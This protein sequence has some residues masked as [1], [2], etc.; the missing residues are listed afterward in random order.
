MD[1]Y[2]AE[3]CRLECVFNNKLDVFDCKNLLF[4]H[5]TKYRLKIMTQVFRRKLD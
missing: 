3:T 2:G 5:T 4:V 1:P